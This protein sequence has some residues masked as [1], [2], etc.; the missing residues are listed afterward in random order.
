[1]NRYHMSDMRER[2]GMVSLNQMFEWNA[3]YCRISIGFDS[4]KRDNAQTGN[5]LRDFPFIIKIS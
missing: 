2:Q 5:C 1:M 3:W 4:N